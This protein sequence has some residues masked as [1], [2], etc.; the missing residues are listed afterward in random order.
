MHITCWWNLMLWRSW[1]AP[2]VA[3]D[4]WWCCRGGSRMPMIEEIRNGFEL[5]VTAAAN[6]EE[7]TV[8]LNLWKG[9]GDDDDLEGESAD[10]G[11]CDDRGP[12][13][14]GLVNGCEWD[15]KPV[16]SK[17]MAA[18]SPE[19][20]KQQ[21]VSELVIQVKQHMLS[22]CSPDI[23]WGFV[24][25]EEAHSGFAALRWGLTPT[26]WETSLKRVN[27]LSAPIL[28]ITSFNRGRP[29]LNSCKTWM[30]INP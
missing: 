27:D 29:P 10:C 5:P 9:V 8:G 15:G 19:D 30:S 20:E 11:W 26:E 18:D 17:M 14:S 16:E 1:T 7:D 4:V 12:S 6:F 28:P 24:T 13:V 25:L 23:N 22:Q 21:N 2:D 3:L